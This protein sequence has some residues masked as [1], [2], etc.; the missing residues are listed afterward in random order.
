MPIVDFPTLV[1]EARGSYPT[2][3]PVRSPALLIMLTMLLPS[4]V[5]SKLKCKT[6]IRVTIAIV[7]TFF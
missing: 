7:A 1:M 6:I 5:A 2:A 4:N 3:L